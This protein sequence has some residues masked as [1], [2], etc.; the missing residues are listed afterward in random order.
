M[1]EASVNACEAPLQIARQCVVALRLLKR[2]GEI[3]V[4]YAV[5]ISAAARPLR[6]RHAAAEL[7]VLINLGNITDPIMGAGP[8]EELIIIAQGGI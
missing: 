6:W 3:G 5:S 4:K 1:S 2:M 7:N 8:R